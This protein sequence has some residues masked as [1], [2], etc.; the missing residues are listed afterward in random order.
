MSSLFLSR[1][2]LSSSERIEVQ[3]RRAKSVALVQAFRVKGVLLLGG[4]LLITAG[5][6]LASFS[7]SPV[8]T[9]Y[10]SL[11]AYAGLPLLLLSM[12]PTDRC[13]HRTAF[14]VAVLACATGFAMSIYWAHG[15]YAPT[16]G[17]PDCFTR[18]R[19][20]G[21]FA[22]NALYAFA[23][24]ATIVYLLVYG[25][26][27]IR[28]EPADPRCCGG[29]RTMPGPPRRVDAGAPTRTTRQHVEALWQGFGV[30]YAYIVA[31]EVRD[32]VGG[33]ATL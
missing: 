24:A 25:S 5:V 21:K 7:I 4:V 23:F 2:S 19:L 22:S 10:G 8:A 16:A 1:A 3:L 20:L 30:G 31:I 12:R 6:A 14:T 11:A 27:T 13:A 32:V 26:P 17:E 15:Y 33:T 18:G 29:R 28:C 9:A